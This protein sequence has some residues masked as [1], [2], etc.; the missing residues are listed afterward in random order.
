MNQGITNGISKRKNAFRQCP[1]LDVIMTKFRP[2]RYHEMET[3]SVGRASPHLEMFYPH[4]KYQKPTFE[5]KKLQPGHNLLWM[6]VESQ[7]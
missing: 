3:I 2:T 5:T 1:K 6:E 7:G 4:A